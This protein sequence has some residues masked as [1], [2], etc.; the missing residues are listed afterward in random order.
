MGVGMVLA[1]NR[2]RHVGCAFGLV[3]AGCRVGA[4]SAIAPELTEVDAGS[5][6]DTA[7]AGAISKPSSDRDSS[8]T[9]TLEAG[10]HAIDPRPDAGGA[11]GCLAVD[12]CVAP[13]N[14]S[15]YMML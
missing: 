11:L 6:Q 10:S 1:G 5:E 4:T 3:L 12:A 2:W 15:K 8:A 7:A 14:L 13:S 9:P